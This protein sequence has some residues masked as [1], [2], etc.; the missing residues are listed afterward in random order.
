MK[1]VHFIQ[2]EMINKNKLIETLIYCILSLITG[3]QNKK[4]SDSGV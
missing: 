1:F 2:I 3:G 4:K